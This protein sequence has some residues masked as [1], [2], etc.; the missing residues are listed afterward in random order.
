[1]KGVDEKCLVP[2]G[3]PDARMPQ[4]VLQLKGLVNTIL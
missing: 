4:S 2:Q 3:T 1:M